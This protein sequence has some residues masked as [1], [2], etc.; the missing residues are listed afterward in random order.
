MA[1]SDPVTRRRIRVAWLVFAVALILAIGWP[2]A[3]IIDWP[4]IRDSHARL[5]YIACD[6]TIVIPLG[7]ATWYGLRRR[8]RWAPLTLLITTGAMAFDA[9]H[10]AVFLSQI[11]FLGLSAG[12]YLPLGVLTLW[13]LFLV[14]RAEIRTLLAELPAS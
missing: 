5:G 7:F 11:G 8:R 13:A 4:S 2:V 14:A 9:F 10:F 12:V 3:A 6:F 1:G